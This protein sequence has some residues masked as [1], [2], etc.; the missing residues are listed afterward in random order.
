M[1]T[2]E[3]KFVAEISE[4]SDVIKMGIDTESQMDME[5][6]LEILGDSM[7]SNKPLTLIREYSTNAY[8]AHVEAGIGDKPIDVFLPSPFIPELKIRDYG[9]GLEP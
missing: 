5:S 4:C 3:K 6:I 7:Y 8:D 2:E 9:F 1:I